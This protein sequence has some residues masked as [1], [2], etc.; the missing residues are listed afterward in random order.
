MI[1]LLLTGGEPLLRPDFFAIYEPL[2]RMGLVLTLFT[3]GTLIT[4]EVARRLAAAPPS[5][6]EITIYGATPETYAAVTGV[7]EGFARCCAG[8]EA[9]LAAHVP[10]LLKCTVTRQNAGEVAAMRAMAEACDVPFLASWRLLHRPDGAES[11]VEACRVSPDAGLDL[12]LQRTKGTPECPQPGAEAERE[13]AAGPQASTMAPPS[14]FR[15]QAGRSA[16]AVNPAGEMNAC[17]TVPRPRSRPLTAGFAAA[18]EDVCRYVDS[19]PPPAA[20]GGC[21]ARAA[22]GYCPAWSWTENGSLAEPPRYLCDLAQKRQER[23]DAC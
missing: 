8:I 19:V 14:A 12:D 13:P 16:F 23:C 21:A 17:I 7:A 1:F 5:R 9:L 15:C 10:L 2:T 4:A 3:N 18:W 6:L 22:C 11:E 20:C